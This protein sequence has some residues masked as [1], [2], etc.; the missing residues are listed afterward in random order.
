MSTEMSGAKFLRLS[1]KPRPRRTQIERTSETRARILVATVES[2]GEVGFQR[3]TSAEISRRSGL[4]WGAVQHHFGSKSGILAAVLEDSFNRF[5]EGLML[6]FEDLGKSTSLAS[7][8]DV[9]VDSAWAHFD[10]V[11]YRAAFEILLEDSASRQSGSP[12]EQTDQSWQIEILKAW[13]RVWRR[14]FPDVDLGRRRAMMIQHYTIAML[15]GLAS[16]Q[17]LSGEA[18]PFVEDELELLKHTL[19]RE[20]RAASANVET[21]P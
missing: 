18:A 6:A 14:L 2:L 12:S 16:M 20:F 11:H 10:S 3:T 17:R 1:E 19:A 21:S 8:I 7:R 5:S 4:T 15:S 9:F 13:T